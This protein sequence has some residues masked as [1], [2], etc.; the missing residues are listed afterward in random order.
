MCHLQGDP[1]ALAGVQARHED[2]QS[3]RQLPDPVEHA[4]SLQNQ[5][6]ISKIAAAQQRLQSTPSLTGAPSTG[7]QGPAP[8]GQLGQIPAG[9]SLQPGD[10]PQGQAGPSSRDQ[11]SPGPLLEERRASGQ[12]GP[13]TTHEAP[14]DAEA[15]TTGMAMD[16][17]GP[18]NRQQRPQVSAVHS[19]ANPVPS[20]PMPSNQSGALQGNHQ[21]PALEA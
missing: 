9:P 8:R 7:P 11:L 13:S 3:L 12:V 14:S 17:P 6:L 18:A 19:C 15:G 21:K 1:W 16:E 4:Y 20:N 10:T 2:R 5:E